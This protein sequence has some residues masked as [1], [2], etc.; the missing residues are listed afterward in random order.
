MTGATL[1]SGT[2][3]FPRHVLV[4]FKLSC[5][6]EPREKGWLCSS[7]PWVP[8]GEMGKGCVVALMDDQVSRTEGVRV[9]VLW[10]AVVV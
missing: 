8:L 6:T 3:F 7:P 4:F 2:F 5:Q 1:P 10:C 9:G